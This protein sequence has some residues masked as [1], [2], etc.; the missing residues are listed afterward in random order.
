MISRRN[1][2]GG[3]AAVTAPALAGCGRGQPPTGAGFASASQAS[4]YPNV[5]GLDAIIDISHNVTVTDF[6]A[7][8]RSGILAVIHKV[9]EGG[10]WFDPSYAPRRHQ[11]ESAGLLWG[12]Y[13]FGTGQYSGAD[14]A[15]AFLRAAQ[16]SATT[17]MSLDVEVNDRR[18]ANSMRLNQAEAFVQTVQQATGRLPMVYVHPRWANGEKMGRGGRTLGGAITPQSILAKC[19]LWLADYREQPEVPYA[20]AGRGWKI[21]Q[22]L[23]DEDDSKAAY[24]TTPRAISGVSHCDRNL[25]NGDTAELYRFWRSKPLGA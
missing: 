12:A 17:V 13:H 7:V 10:D 21:W 9:S 16:P 5:P 22:Y 3:L 14:Q 25:F 2:L 6:A 4:P 11:A 8:R 18:P 20:W 19:D 23:A 15:R 1:L 24:G